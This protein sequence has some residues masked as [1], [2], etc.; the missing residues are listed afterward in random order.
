MMN[1]MNYRYNN[2]TQEIAVDKSLAQAFVSKPRTSEQIERFGIW[3]SMSKEKK[4]M[5]PILQNVQTVSLE[6]EKQ[7]IR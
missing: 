6:Q 3:A 5:E 4:E 2:P 7:A 1:E